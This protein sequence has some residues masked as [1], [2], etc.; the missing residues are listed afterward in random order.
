MRAPADGAW[1]APTALGGDSSGRWVGGFVDQHVEHR[2]DAVL[3]A[4]GRQLLDQRR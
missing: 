2:A 1:A 3:G 4:L